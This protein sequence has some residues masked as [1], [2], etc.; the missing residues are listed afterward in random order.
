MK[1]RFYMWAIVVLL[2]A[3]AILPVSARVFGG[4]MI[5][6]SLP[7]QIFVAWSVWSVP[8]SPILWEIVA[9]LVYA[10]LILSPSAAWAAT[11]RRSWLVAQLGVLLL[12]VLWSA[13]NASSCY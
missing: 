4:W 3:A 13:Y 11:G 7:Y 2:I 8:I 1:L 9:A 6:I 5:L 12:L 10:G